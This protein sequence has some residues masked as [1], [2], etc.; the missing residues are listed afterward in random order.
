MVP[1]ASV[2]MMDSAAC[3]T[4]RLRRAC[5]SSARLRS[6]MSTARPTRPSARPSSSRSGNREVS[7]VW[8]PWAPGT[9]SSISVRAFASN[10]ARSS[11]RMR[12]AT[13]AGKRSWAVLPTAWSR[14]TP[15]NRS[16]AVLTR[17]KRRSQSFTKTMA[18][19]PSRIDWRNCSF[20]W[21]SAMWR[22]GSLRSWA[23]TSSARR[24]LKRTSCAVTRAVNS[25]PSLRRCRQSAGPRN[26]IAFEAFTSTTRAGT[27]SCGRMS[28]MV[29]RSNSSRL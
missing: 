3:S 25:W 11:R 24:S 12:S 8:S 20:L 7:W 28:A 9:V 16:Q 4:T 22:S 29:I 19:R 2:I 18:G 14:G 27:S 23:N 10:I 21:T 13:S 15:V 6:V 1:S 26:P 17:V 5:C